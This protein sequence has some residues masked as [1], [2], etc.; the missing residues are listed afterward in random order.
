MSTHVMKPM[1]IGSLIMLV[2]GLA[3]G[4][5]PADVFSGKVI[6]STTPFP[7]GF[8][9]DRAFIR[10]MKKVNKKAVRYPASNR[11]SIEFMGFFGRTYAATEYTCLIYNVTE[12]NK[13]VTSFP[14]YPEARENRILASGFQI[15]RDE[16]P[17]ERHYRLIISLNGRI[18]AETTFAIKENAANRKARLEKER[19]LKN[20]KVNF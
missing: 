16:F 6:I 9:N 11:L 13:L 17:E 19:A 2:G 7:S 12:R 3:Y 1:I 18:L 10:H 20:Q 14:I 8:K 15:G 4:R 5:K